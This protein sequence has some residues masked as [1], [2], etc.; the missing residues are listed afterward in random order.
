[1][2]S[3]NNRLETPHVGEVMLFDEVP[4]CFALVESL[5]VDFKLPQLQA[6]VARVSNEWSVSQCLIIQWY[7]VAVLSFFTG[8]DEV[9]NHV[10][11]AVLRGQ[12]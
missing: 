3:E 2:L 7:I 5:C 12:E 6:G 4:S 1:V 10:W 9:E 8:A 11:T